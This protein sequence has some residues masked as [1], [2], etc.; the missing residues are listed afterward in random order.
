MSSSDKNTDQFEPLA[1]GSLERFDDEMVSGADKTAPDFDRFKLLFEESKFKEDAPIDFEALFDENPEKEEALFEA[2]PGTGEALLKKEPEAPGLFSEEP[3]PEEPLKD[4]VPEISP[5]EKGYQAGHEKGLEEG[6]IQGKEEGYQEGFAEGKKEGAAAG[7]Q[8]GLEKGHAEGLEKGL[9][10]GKQKGEEEAKA[11]AKQ[12]LAS[13]DQ[14]L[15]DADQTL[16]LLVDR[17]EDRIIGLI[18]EITQ[19]IILA[20]LEIDDEI[21]KPMILEA[22]KTLVNPEEITLNVSTEDYEYIEMVKDDFFEAVDSLG[23]VAVKSDPSFRKG[24]FTIE[25]TTGIVS[26]DMESKLE[27]VFEAV[28]A[29]G[30]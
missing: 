1:I 15:Q 10:E 4:V 13:L 11:E 12:R 24:D 16:E 27:A 30:R 6:L 17:Y 23:R 3:S 29:A 14:I 18:Q 20:R 5:E 9:L 21:I 25:T 2:L 8:E 19:K 22:L 7:E 26:S 28:K